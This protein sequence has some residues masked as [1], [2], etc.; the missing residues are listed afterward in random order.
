MNT[1]KLTT[2]GSQ[3]QLSE[4]NCRW[5]W[6]CTFVCAITIWIP[7]FV[8]AA[9]NPV[10]LEEEV[11]FVTDGGAFTGTLYVP[12]SENPVPLLILY[13]AAGGG[14]VNFP[15]YAHL[16]ASLPARGIA[17]F[18][19]NR[20]GTEG[21]P[22]DF[23]TSSFEDLALDGI[24]AL[25]I[26]KSDPRINASRIG[27]WGIS[28]GGWIA[29]LA[30]TL[31]DDLSFVISVSGP[32]VTPAE[33][34]SFAAAFHLREAGFAEQEIEQAL[35]LRAEIDAYYRNPVDRETLQSR[36]DNFSDAPWFPLAFLPETLPEDVT[37]DKWFY[38]MDFDPIPT[39]SR[40]DK[41]FL[42]I[43]GEKDRWVP[44]VDSINAIRAAYPD[45]SRLSVY[46]SRQ[47]GHFISGEPE[48]PDYMGENP[49]ESQ[50]LERMAAWIKDL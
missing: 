35:Q 18:I 41:P 36:I 40:M 8:C 37:T 50:Y 10:I 28:Q 34:M 45:K 42:V 26:L 24:A 21:Q 29:P 5:K 19:Y 11:A 33:Q 7:H 47:S 32:G 16:K 23:N 12:V 3:L 27:A 9:G 49:V 38:E 4:F 22:G 44:V 39:I 48:D 25:K 30:S 46:V 2:T 1:E 20:R 17:T 31:S 14:S 13:H 6:R 43:Y 15:F